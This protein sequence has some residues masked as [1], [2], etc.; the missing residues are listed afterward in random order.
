MSEKFIKK[1]EKIATRDA[2]GKVLIQLGKENKDII[3]L[4]ADLSQSTK[5]AG[6]AKAYPERFFNMGIAEQN[7]IGFSAGLALP[8]ANTAKV[9]AKSAFRQ[10]LCG[11]C[12]GQSLRTDKE[13]GSIS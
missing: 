5:T 1:I 4:D 8:V 13:F 6:F 3:V 10:Y 11:V 2:Y 12:H 7:L 9:L